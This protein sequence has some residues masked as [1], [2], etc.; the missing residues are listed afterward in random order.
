MRK[1]W[2][3]LCLL[4]ALLGPLAA[5]AELPRVGVGAYSGRDTF[6]TSL[7]GQIRERGQGRLDLHIVY[8]QG[9]QN[10]QN[11]QILQ[12]IEDGVDV[13]MV[14]P[15][16]RVSAVYL[17]ALARQHDLPLILFNREPLR[18]DLAAYDRAYYVGIDPRRQGELQGE[19]AAAYFRAHPEQDLNGDGIIQYVLLRGEPGHQ[20]AELR[21]LFSLRAMTAQGLRTQKLAEETAY[22]EKGLGQ[23]R[24]AMLLNAYGRR[25]ELVIANNDDMALGAIDA[26]KAA[27]YFAGSQA[28]P[29]IGVDATAPAL[30]AIAQGALYGTVQNDAARQAQA[31]VDL[32]VLLAAD[33]PVDAD[34]Y[35]FPLNERVVY[36]PSQAITQDTLP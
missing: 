30:E 29:V 5:R 7:V 35:P 26:L 13:L 28:I 16:D 20:D 23:E 32:A 9:D 27:G 33:Q 31:V 22:W 24:M 21:S 11:D 25:V 1:R 10:R 6:I 19:L 18:E 8:A 2:L 3:T 15:V 34:S 4:L 14:N 12:M 17:I 36:I